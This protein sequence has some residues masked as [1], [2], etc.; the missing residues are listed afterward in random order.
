[1]R[2][3]VVVLPASMCADADIAVALYGC[4]AGHHLLLVQQFQIR[5]AQVRQ[6]QTNS[7][8]AW[9]VTLSAA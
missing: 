7:R 8:A 4:L 5:E 2:S 3:V 6:F 1:M 9:L